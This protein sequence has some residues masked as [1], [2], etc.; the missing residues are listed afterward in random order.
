VSQQGE[1]GDCR[2]YPG[3]VESMVALR[4]EKKVYRPEKKVTLQV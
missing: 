1:E 4:L 3:D 2:E